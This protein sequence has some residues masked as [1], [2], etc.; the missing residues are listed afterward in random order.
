MIGLMGKPPASFLARVAPELQRNWVDED[1]EWCFKNKEV[2]VSRLRLEE[3]ERVLTG[4]GKDSRQ[5]LAF[6][7]RILV[8]D[9]EKRATASQL[10]SDPW[11]DSLFK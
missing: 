8:W 1:G 5:F 9:P 3:E 6:M 11:L 2:E 4:A 10:L 7:K